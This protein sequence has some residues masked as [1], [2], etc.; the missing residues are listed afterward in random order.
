[1]SI[2]SNI[3]RITNARNDSFTAVGGKGVTVPS[4]SS[5]D[6][7]P[8]LINQIQTDQGVEVVETQDQAG[9]TVVSITAQPIVPYNW[10]GEKAEFVQKL[11]SN[12]IKLKDTTFDTWTPSTTAKAIV[13]SAT[14]TSFSADL[15]NYEYCVRWKY[16]ADVKYVDGTVPKAAPS[17]HIVTLWSYIYKRPSD[18][19]NVVNETPNGNAVSNYSAPLIEYYNTSGNLTTAYTA[20]YGIYA[21]ANSPTFSNAT[22]NTPTVT[23]KTPTISARCSSTYMSTTM[24]ANINKEESTVNYVADL[25]R[26]E[27]GSFS[28]N[29][30]ADSIHLLNTVRV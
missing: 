6:D 20:S 1:M 28:D 4:G 13:P 15:A 18:R 29:F 24:A 9:G 7:L 26:M 22:S 2:Q 10:M 3:T 11:G 5:I 16:H 14:L 23:V 27:K 12:S 25:F 21:A 17:Y 8:T 19:T 30:Y